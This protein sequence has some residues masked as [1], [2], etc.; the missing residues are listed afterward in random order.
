M[1]LLSSSL[2][3]HA[4][5]SLP[6]L[7]RPP[8]S[9]PTYVQLNYI[10]PAPFSSPSLSAIHAPLTAPS[11]LQHCSFLAPRTQPE[12]SKP[13]ASFMAKIHLLHSLTL[14]PPSPFPAYLS[15]GAFPSLSP[16][17]GQTTGLNFSENRPRQTATAVAAA[18]VFDVVKRRRRRACSLTA[19]NHNSILH[20]PLPPL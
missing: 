2:V 15:R 16:M 7:S 5:P 19:P 10:P 3:Y 8:P 6:R 11:L 17:D 9:L 4:I 1:C 13:P 20:P 18:F 12:P 14:S